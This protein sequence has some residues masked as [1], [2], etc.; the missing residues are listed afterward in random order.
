MGGN[1]VDYSQRTADGPE[2]DQT[3]TLIRMMRQLLPDGFRSTSGKD[4]F[5]VTWGD[6]VS[7]KR[8]RD[9]LRD[10]AAGREGPAEE[11]AAMA[12]LRQESLDEKPWSSDE[13]WNNP[14]EVQK[15]TRK[16]L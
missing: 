14:E 5:Q 15:Y 2:G 16:K 9:L 10:S 1:N 13:F 4:D 6:A 8:L 7:E 12:R 11:D 3:E